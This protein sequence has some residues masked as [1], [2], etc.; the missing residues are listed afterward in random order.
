MLSRAE[1]ERLELLAGLAEK[2]L[3]TLAYELI[4]RGLRIGARGPRTP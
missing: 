2:P 1:M 4:V 3:A